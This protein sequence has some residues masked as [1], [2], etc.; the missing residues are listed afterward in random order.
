[1][2][3]IEYEG[4]TAGASKTVTLQNVKYGYES[5][6]S[7]S[8]PTSPVTSGSFSVSFSGTVNGVAIDQI[9]AFNF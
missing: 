4:A 2:T 3:I 5:S 8:S 6:I 1:M 9:F 7:I